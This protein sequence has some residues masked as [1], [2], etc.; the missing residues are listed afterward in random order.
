[1][2]DIS[3]HVHIYGDMPLPIQPTS[4]VEDHLACVWHMVLTCVGTCFSHI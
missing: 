1:M 2:S 3:S 4:K